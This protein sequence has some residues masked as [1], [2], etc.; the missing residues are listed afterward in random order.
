MVLELWM[1]EFVDG[2]ARAHRR[3][4]SVAQ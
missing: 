3:R 4:Q 2:S 1:R